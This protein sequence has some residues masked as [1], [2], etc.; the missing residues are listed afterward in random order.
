MGSL[1]RIGLTGGIA[2]GKSTVAQRF[3]ELGV[4]VVDAD[5]SS[6][7]VVAPGTPGLARIREAFG[8]Q[9]LTVSGELDRR[10]LR[11]LIFADPNSRRK[12]ESILHPLIRADMETRAAEAGGSYLIMAIPLL[13]ERDGSARVNRVLVVD[14]P[15][16]VQLRRVM[17]RDGCDAAQAHA[18]LAAQSSREDRLKA[19]DDVLLNDGTVADLRQAVDGLHQRYL[20]MAAI[21]SR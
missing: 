5:E 17:A 18:I 16:E 1:F 2:S 11:E 7:F 13:I 19:A 6:R 15:E 4:P 3:S 8:A 12:L 20:K 9:I 10:A 14:V 21:S